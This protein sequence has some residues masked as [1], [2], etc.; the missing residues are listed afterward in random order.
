[1]S[2]V[3]VARFTYRHQAEFARG[4][5]ADAGISARVM[6][7]DAG[8]TH[9]NL[10]FLTGVAVIVHADA[11]EAA[12]AALRDAGLFDESEGQGGTNAEESV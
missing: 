11:A 3:V 10:S 8:A 12:A 4:F 7:D 9:P 6:S 1:M 5:L 2:E